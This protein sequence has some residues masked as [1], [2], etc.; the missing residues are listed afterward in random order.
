MAEYSKQNDRACK[1]KMTTFK[2]IE[3]KQYDGYDTDLNAATA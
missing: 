3:R 1:A 2:T